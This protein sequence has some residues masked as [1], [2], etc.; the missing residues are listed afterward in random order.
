MLKS[1]VPLSLKELRG[2]LGLTG[3]Y[4]CFVAN[5]GSIAW[6]LTQLLRKDNFHW[7]LEAESTFQSLKVAM[8]Q[9]PVLAL[10]N[11]SKPFI[12]ETCTSSMGIGAV[13]LQDQRSNAFFS[14]ALPPFARLKSVYERELMAV[15][16]AV[17]KWRHYLMGCRFIVCTD[18][19]SLNFLLVQRMVT[20]DHQKWL[21]KLFGYDFDIE[22]KTGVANRMANTLSRI[23]SHPTL[24]SIS[25][26]R[27]LQLEN[28][29]REI[30]L[31]PTLAPIQRALSQ[32]QPTTPGYSLI[33]G[34]L[35]YINKLVI[36][37]TS[38]LIPLLLH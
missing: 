16:R 11:F 2:F 26:P 36:P 19:R 5:Y 7:G 3:Y 18:Q 12:V 13:L 24:L 38:T 9:L 8:T 1:P 35:F 10:P 22:Y 6:P 34:R 31:D 20:L 28:L 32:G 37:A 23:P 14:Q 30:A 27:V 15:V 21:C 33:Q 4:Q 17:Q 29:P 25:V